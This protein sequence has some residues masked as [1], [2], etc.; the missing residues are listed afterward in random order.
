M[1][2]ASVQL[3]VAVLGALFLQ[4]VNQDCC[5]IYLEFD[6]SCRNRRKLELSCT[7]PLRCLEWLREKR[8][9]IAHCFW[10]S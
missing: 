1:V 6:S 3:M 7:Q 9:Q 2:M 8:L 4:T 10:D 5:H